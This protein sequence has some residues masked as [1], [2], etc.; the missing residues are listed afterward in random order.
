MSNACFQ[1]FEGLRALGAMEVW[2]VLDC[3]YENDETWA[4]LAE[5]WKQM[6]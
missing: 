4:V 3:M 1:D 6:P 5:R 2:P